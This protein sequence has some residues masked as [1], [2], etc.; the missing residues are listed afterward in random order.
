MMKR[1]MR[2]GVSAVSRTWGGTVR[3]LGPTWAALHLHMRALMVA[4]QSRA[5]QS[6]HAMQSRRDRRVEVIDG[7]LCRA[8]MERPLV[9][10]LVYGGGGL[11]VFLTLTTGVLWWR[12]T[13]GPL[14]LDM[15]TPL[16]T[17]AVEERLGGGHR[18]EVGGSQLERDDNGRTAL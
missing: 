16:L 10:W 14:S 6:R 18:I 8:W 7:R 12:L 13:S 5:V 15:A 9:R 17:S 2:A 1:H 11:A 3:A 4:A